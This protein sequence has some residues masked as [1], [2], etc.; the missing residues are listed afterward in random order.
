MG[1]LDEIRA[2][3]GAAR[4][5]RCPIPRAQPILGKGDWEDLKAAL[6]DPAITHAAISRALKRHNVDASQGA[7]SKHRKGECACGDL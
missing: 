1:L 7:V 6:V 5:P 4:G 2:E 3:V